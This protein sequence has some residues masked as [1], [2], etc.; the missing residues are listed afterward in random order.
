MSGF[1]TVL[2][3]NDHLCLYTHAWGFSSE[4]H[5]RPVRAGTKGALQ[6]VSFICIWHTSLL[7]YSSSTI[8]L[9]TVCLSLPPATPSSSYRFSFYTTENMRWMVYDQICTSPTKGWKSLV[10]SLK[11]T[12][13]F[14][15]SQIIPFSECCI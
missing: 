4:M 11:L 7:R 12:D 10:S 9:I 1:V 6:E 15:F 8:I 13:R 14:F 2:Q 5:G 3:S